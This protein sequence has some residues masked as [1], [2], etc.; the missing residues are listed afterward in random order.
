MSIVRNITADVAT[1]KPFVVNGDFIMYFSGGF[2][3]G[4]A[5]LERRNLD[6]TYTDIIGGSYTEPATIEAKSGKS[7]RYRITVTGSTTPTI[8]VEV[9]GATDFNE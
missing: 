4:T 5:Q 6:G 2:G 1:P 8:R 7:E 3:G 9:P